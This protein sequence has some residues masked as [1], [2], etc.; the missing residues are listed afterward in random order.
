[1]WIVPWKE[2]NDA[3]SCEKESNWDQKGDEWLHYKEP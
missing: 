1:M 3:N 2:A